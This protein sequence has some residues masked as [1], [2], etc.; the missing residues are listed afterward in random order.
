MTNSISRES[1]LLGG[2]TQENEMRTQRYTKYYEFRV[3]RKIPA[4]SSQVPL[5]SLLPVTAKKINL[6]KVV[7]PPKN[8]CSCFF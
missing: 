7:K 1:A 8:A 4:R 3:C 5:T 6:Y 2:W